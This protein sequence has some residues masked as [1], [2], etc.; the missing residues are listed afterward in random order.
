ME[1]VVKD[2]GLY[3]VFSKIPVGEEAKYIWIKKEAVRGG[4]YEFP[5]LFYRLKTADELQ[6]DKIIISEIKTD[7]IVGQPG[8]MNYLDRFPKSLH[9][10]FDY[11]AANRSSPEVEFRINASDPIPPYSNN[12]NKNIIRN[13]NVPQLG[14]YYEKYLKYKSKYLELKNKN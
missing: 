1:E 8:N 3:L 2:P 4:H 7:T 12:F 14:G 10:Y 5:E 11:T 13:K 9:K 6:Q